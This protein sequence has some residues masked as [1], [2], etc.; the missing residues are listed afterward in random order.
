M[1]RFSALLL[2]LTTLVAPTERSNGRATS[3]AA[4]SLSGRWDIVVR[5][6]SGNAP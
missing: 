2:A 5:T 4:D 3:I 1:W 6:E